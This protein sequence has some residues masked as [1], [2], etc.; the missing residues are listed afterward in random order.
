[1]NTHI[2]IP[3]PH[4]ETLGLLLNTLLADEQVLYTKTK[5]YHWNVE[6]ENFQELHAFFDKQ[7]EELEAMIDQIA[8]RVRAL[9]HYAVGTLKD[10]LALTR[11]LET[12]DDGGDARRMLHNL[13]TDH[14]TLIRLLRKGVQT[15]GELNDAGTSDFLTDLL[16][17]HEKMAWMLRAYLPGAKRERLAPASV[18]ESAHG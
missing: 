15:A 6:A 8:E 3:A 12:K 11:L 14:E 10:F 7:A 13:F 17:I 18:T 9:G 1:M 2:G 4:L 16:E 5:Y